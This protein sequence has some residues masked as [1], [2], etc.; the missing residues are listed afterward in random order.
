M[1][2]RFRRLPLGRGGH[3]GVGVQGEPGT[4]VAQHAGHRFHVYPV[5]QSQSCERV[6]QIMEPNSWKSRPFQ[7]P[8][9]H[10]EHTVRGHGAACGA[11][12]HPGAAT[13]FLSLLI[14]NV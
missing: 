4:V 8:V 3:V 11:G 2:H 1:F 13:H 6:P 14:Q 12:E 7:R 10:V 9:E 5:L